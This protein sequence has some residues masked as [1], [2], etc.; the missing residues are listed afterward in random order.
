MMWKRWR[1][2]H[3]EKSS[4]ISSGYSEQCL[5]IS[6]GFSRCA[7]PT[8]RMVSLNK[9]DKSKG[10]DQQS[11]R[12]PWRQNISSSVWRIDRNYLQFLGRSDIKQNTGWRIKNLP[13]AR[14]GNGLDIHSFIF[15]SL[16][17]LSYWSN[18]SSIWRSCCSA[19]SCNCS[20]VLRKHISGIHY[21][22]AR[23]DLT[24]LVCAFCARGAGKEDVWLGNACT[25][26]HL[27]HVHT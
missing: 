9:E 26:V 16:F 23:K 17:S 27:A 7:W 5:T 3:I 20:W 4:V 21:E 22:Q 6:G 18:S 12:Q 24:R 11:S 1:M 14:V 13:L 8:T 10:A 25:Y 15:C 2:T 19:L